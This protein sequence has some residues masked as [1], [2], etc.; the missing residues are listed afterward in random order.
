MAEHA[1]GMEPFADAAAGFR[2]KWE[3]VQAAALSRP[4]GDPKALA[5]AARAMADWCQDFLTRVAGH[6]KP[7]YSKAETQ[8]L[9]D[10]VAAAALSDRWTADPEAAMHLTWAYLALRKAAGRPAAED[11]VAELAKAIPTRVRSEPY[12]TPDGKP[13]TAGEMIEQ[14]MRVFRNYEPKSFQAA[15]RALG[16]G[17]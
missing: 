4:F 8:R 5:A 1:A 16:E 11:K 12:S 15:F 7:V 9:I 10:R 14:R 3:A 6:P 2:P 13:Q 17:K